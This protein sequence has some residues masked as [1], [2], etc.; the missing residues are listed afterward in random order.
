MRLFVVALAVSL[1]AVSLRAEP[2]ARVTAITKDGRHAGTLPVAQVEVKTDKAAVKVPLAQV[3]SVRGG[4]AD[5]GD[6][7]RTRDGKR[8][9]GTVRVDGWTLQEA[10]GELPLTRA[11]LR[12]VVPQAPIGPLKRGQ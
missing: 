3:S 2:P 8:V 1:L 10:S 5:K 11:D 4:E 7:V 12:Y 6:V 9:K